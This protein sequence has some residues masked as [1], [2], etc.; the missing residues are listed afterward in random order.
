MELYNEILA[1]ALAD[2]MLQG[3]HPEREV[4]AAQLVE[5]RCCRAL[6]QIRDILQDDS[7]DD[8]EC[9]ARIE[10]IL[11][12]LEELGSDGGVRHDFG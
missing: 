4:D 2:W 9:F 6:Q 5:G 1:R 7:L 3:A 11:C 8:P 12:V 10:A